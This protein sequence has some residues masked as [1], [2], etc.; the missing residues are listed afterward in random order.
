MVDIFPSQDNFVK[1]NLYFRFL[2]R[3]LGGIPMMWTVIS[4]LIGLTLFVMIG[5]VSYPQQTI[6]D[7][8]S[9][10][11]LREARQVSKELAEKVRGL[12]LQE[13][14]R[15]GFVNAVRVCSESAQKISQQ[16]N[17]NTGHYARRVSLR[18]RNPKNIPDDYERRKLE[19]FD[20]LNREKRLGN[21]YVEVVKE[22]NHVYLRYMRPLV[23]IP[24]CLVCHGPK[25]NIPSEIK[26]ILAEKYPDD[27]A[28]GFLNGD[29]R[30]TISVRIALP[31]RGVR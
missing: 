23:V 18:V 25:E 28:T 4:G 10:Q 2:S 1:F 7:S 20:L 15:G 16:F 22:G 30:G 11:A 6:P 31:Q 21:E 24:L 9:E 14:E 8:R 17:K 5:G 3:F 12:L 29:V 27:R 26:T 19:E 13:I